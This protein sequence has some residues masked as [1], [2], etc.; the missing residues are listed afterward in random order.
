MK[1]NWRAITTTALFVGFF[2]AH[3]YFWLVWAIS[4]IFSI[5]VA[6][7]ERHNISQIIKDNVFL[8]LITAIFSTIAYFLAK[9]S[10]IHH[11]N[12][13]YG[14][15]AEYLNHSA[16]AWAGF[17]GTIFFIS[18]PCFLLALYFF[19]QSAKKRQLKEMIKGMEL[20]VHCASC[21][22]ICTWLPP[23]Y[24]IAEQH[25]K[26]LL[27]LDAYSHS[28]CNPP[29]NHVAIRKDQ[30]TCYLIISKGVLDLQLQPYPA[31]K[32]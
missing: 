22:W 3:Q 19:F 11:F 31:K 6:W 17:V 7:I 18:I 30:Q 8:G 9:V 1:L 16:T 28:D 26:T 4:F 2:I 29:K 12:E 13:K 25:D 5:T 15:F 14:I 32:P 10:A 21:L 23:M 24:Q 20:I 27:Y